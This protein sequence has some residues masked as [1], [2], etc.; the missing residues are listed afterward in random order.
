MS[1]KQVIPEK[2][3]SDKKAKETE[4]P[5][6]SI[7]GKKEGDSSTG[8]EPSRKGSAT[9][10]SGSGSFKSGSWRGRS[11]SGRKSSGSID[12][13]KSEKLKWQELTATRTELWAWLLFDTANSPYYQVMVGVVFNLLF[14]FIGSRVGCPFDYN[15]DA[16]EL[17]SS[18]FSSVDYTATQICATNTTGW[19]TNISSNNF[20]LTNYKAS[21]QQYTF[22]MTNVP[23]VTNSLNETL[24]MSGFS[25]EVVSTSN[26]N[27]INTSGVTF[28]NQTGYQGHLNLT[29]TPAADWVTGNS[30]VTWKLSYNNPASG[31]V[32]WST[33]RTTLVKVVASRQTCNE[34]I[35]YFGMMQS[36]ASY[37][38]FTVSLSVICQI[39]V[40]ITVSSFADFGSYRKSILI[41][42][43]T[44]CV[45]LVAAH[46]FL[47]YDPRRFYVL[48]GV[49]MIL[50]NVCFGVAI[51]M[52]NSQMPFLLKCHPEVRKLIDGGKAKASEIVT[53]YDELIE[54]Y[55]TH[56]IAYG[57]AGGVFMLL[58]SIAMIFVFGQGALTYVLIFD[59]CA[60]WML[61][62]AMPMYFM[63]RPRPGVKLPKGVT[64]GNKMLKIATFSFFRFYN[65][66]QNLY[67]LPEHA[68]FVVG[69][70]IYT[71]SYSTCTK[72][73]VLF[74][75]LELNMDILSVSLL[76]IIVPLFCLF[77]I[78][79]GYL[80]RKKLGCSALKMVQYE[81]ILLSL[82]P[83][84]GLLGFIDALPIGIKSPTEMFFLAGLLGIVLGPIE[85]HSRIAFLDFIPPGQTSE[86]FALFEIT[87]KGS[88]WV[89]PL[90]VSVLWNAVGTMRIGFVYLALTIVISL[91]ILF[92]VDERK[93]VLD[94]QSLKI[95]IAIKNMK[96]KRDAQFAQIGQ[97]KTG[98]GLRKFLSLGSSLGSS[99]FGSSATSSSASSVSSFASSA[100][101]IVSSAIT[102]RAS[103][104][105]GS[106]Y[107]S[108]AADLVSEIED[109]DD[110]DDLIAADDVDGARMGAHLEGKDDEDSKG[111]AALMAAKKK[112]GKN[113]A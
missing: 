33:Q 4:I 10:K 69:Y 87:D 52:Y 91:Y 28:G 2:K 78:I 25:V 12:K 79:A 24:T 20:T 27:V 46:P 84:L 109:L 73:G 15:I 53:K 64:E 39:I 104:V 58:V 38:T 19:C 113:K 67:I 62:V 54:M 100:A 17:P 85:N 59:S 56:G 93:A 65:V 31:T 37:T 81:L 34:K 55:G 105:E 71:D 68:K 75:M 42:S 103:T 106:T 35:L 83:T 63:Y 50:E 99:A 112:T 86:Y 36:I 7:S 70:F 89:G 80:I 3:M 13:K 49:F 108:S 60:A 72:I 107:E 51:I 76:G 14:V 57:Y 110:D 61:L 30:F 82:M 9:K 74:A 66:I 45:I 92:I 47:A 40:F 101:S 5:A 48:N 95:A 21:P 1:S 6:K 102:S 41:V 11:G 22:N 16:T 18:L 77:G 90:V 94:A 32:T 44:S 111:L 23:G 26:P 8:S 97:G 88:S 43:Y 29:F 98:A 96:K